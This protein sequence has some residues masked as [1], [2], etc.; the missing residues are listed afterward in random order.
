MFNLNHY[1]MSNVKQVK[2][3][4]PIS[5]HKGIFYGANIV[6]VSVPVDASPKEIGKAL[7]SASISA[8]FKALDEPIGGGNKLTRLWMCK[9]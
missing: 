1:K 4:Q 2:H 5:S 7:A 9:N 8:A 6:T 3:R